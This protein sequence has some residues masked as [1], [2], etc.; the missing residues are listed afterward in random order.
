MVSGSRLFGGDPWAIGSTIRLNGAPLT[1]IG[2]A[3]RDFDFPEKT[4]VW[5]PT[6]YDFDRIPAV[7]V[8]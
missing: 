2:V 8:T 7:G 1:V 6:A 3:P 5:T 4:A